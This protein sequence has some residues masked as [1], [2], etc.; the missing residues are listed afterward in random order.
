M[1]LGSIKQF[2]SIKSFS[3][4]IKTSYTFSKHNRMSVN[5][6]LVDYIC[7]AM[8]LLCY[9]SDTISLFLKFNFSRPGWMCC[10]FTQNS[11]H[12]LTMDGCALRETLIRTR[13]EILHQN[14]NQ[15]GKPPSG[16]GTMAICLDIWG[17]RGRERRVNKDY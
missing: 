11:G 14:P 2:P 7:V 12:F 9:K 6:C 16:Q 10:C 3:N 17:W 8:M 13:K 5:K 4:F 15:E 1:F